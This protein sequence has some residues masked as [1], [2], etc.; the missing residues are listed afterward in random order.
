M[1]TLRLSELDNKLAAFCSSTVEMQEFVCK[2]CA[3][4]NAE[5][6]QVYTKLETVVVQSRVDTSILQLH[7]LDRKTG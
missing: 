1:S 4:F 3:H 2:T 5:Q 7:F 6:A